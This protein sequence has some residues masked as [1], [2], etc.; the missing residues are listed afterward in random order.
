MAT[1]RGR[2]T[3]MEAKKLDLAVREAAVA[4]FLEM[5]YAGATMEAI[6]RSAGITKRSLYARYPDKRAV[7]ADVIPWALARYTDDAAIEDIDEDDIEGTLL[8][9]GRAALERA[10]HPENVR[11]KR[12]AF[13]EA[14]LFPEFKISA[15]S[16]MWAGRQRAVTE[17]LRR[18]ADLGVI[19]V[20]DLELAAEHFLAMVE[21]VPARMAD[22]GVF[23]SKK[24]QERHLQYAVRLF[25]RGVMPR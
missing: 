15:E 12:I 20:E 18:Y 19:D 10:T 7:F 2:P 4:T 11:L 24:Q 5:G 8:K 16:M 23:R 21:A 25:L 3:Q 1:R 22:F 17:V 14:A 6:A 9:L 13:N